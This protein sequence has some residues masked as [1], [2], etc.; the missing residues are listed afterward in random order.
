VPEEGCIWWRKLPTFPED[1]VHLKYVGNFA[2]MGTRP[3]RLVVQSP[4]S[5]FG[6]SGS[7]G[8]V[9]VVAAT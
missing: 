9:S 6:D 4:G 5:V 8:G 1:V 7:D 2:P 3:D